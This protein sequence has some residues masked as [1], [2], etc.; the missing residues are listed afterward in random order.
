VVHGDAAF[1]K[2]FIAVNTLD[3]ERG[4]V[5]VFRKKPQLLIHPLLDLL[6]EHFII[7]FERGLAD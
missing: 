3:A 5:R 4:M 1:P 2:I 6:R 7:P